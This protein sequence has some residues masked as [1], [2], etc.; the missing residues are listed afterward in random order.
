MQCQFDALIDF[1]YNCGSGAL[2]KSGLINFV[3]GIS[4]KTAS[5]AFMVYTHDANGQLQQ[6]LIT[7][8]KQEA[9]MWTYGKYEM[10]Y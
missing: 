6:G 7:R 8:R 2:T 1:A 5:D 4:N 9:D 3:Y 10:G